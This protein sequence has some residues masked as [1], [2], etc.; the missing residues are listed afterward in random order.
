MTVFL[1]VSIFSKAAI[2]FEPLKTYLKSHFRPDLVIPFRSKM[3]ILPNV[4]SISC[5]R[6]VRNDPLPVNVELRRSRGPIIARPQRDFEQIDEV[7]DNRLW[8]TGKCRSCGPTG[9]SRVID[10]C[11][12]Q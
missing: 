9:R 11:H 1:E 12:N 2:I 4:S 7:G 6:Y 10:L 5:N 3:T 8:Q